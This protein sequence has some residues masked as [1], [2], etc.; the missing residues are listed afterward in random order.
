MS[1]ETT[2][3]KGQAFLDKFA[4]VSGRIG[5]E[6]HLRSLRDAFA[7]IMPLYILAGIAVLINNVLFPLFLADEALANAQYWGNALTLGTLNISA[8]L[9]A[10]VVGYCHAHNMRYERDIACVVVAI[11]AFFVTMPQSVEVVV[12]DVTGMVSGVFLTANTGTNGLFGAIIIGLLATALFIKLS[13]IDQLKI[14]LGEGVP[15][16]VAGSF[17]V[18]IPM[19]LTL[20]AFGLLSAV[21]YVGFGTNLADVIKLVVQTPLQALNSNIWGVVIIYTFANLLFCLGIHQSAISGVLA[22]PM[23]TI[24]ITENM[25]AYASGGFAA[26]QPDHYMNMQIVNTFGLIG[27][28]GCTLCLLIATFLFSKSKTSKTIASLAIGPGI[29]NINEPVIYGYPIVYNLPLMVP[30]VL[31]PDLFMIITYFATTMGLIN[32][33]VV[34]V[35]WTTPV[36]LSGFLATAGDFRAVILQVI[37]VVLGVLIYL[38]F[39]KVHERV[40]AQQA[41]ANA[42]VEAA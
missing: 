41:D 15:P 33:C 12:N 24:L 35:P 39:M 5:S 27:G 9:L 37:L 11:S 20:A 13:S 14:N 23:L 30:F 28:S 31:I 10:G 7:T 21:L 3:S 17:N 40:Q 29:F 38:P 8:I 1:E 32:P 34:M 26:I 18:M 16:A 36:F 22:E 25:S 2:T 42:E 6:V 4:A 19:L